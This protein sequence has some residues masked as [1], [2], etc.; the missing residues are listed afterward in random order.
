MSC[1]HKI[2][3][4]NPVSFNKKI[5]ENER[6]LNSQRRFF[7]TFNF[8]NKDFDKWW[9]NHH[10]AAFIFND[11]LAMPESTRYLSTNPEAVK[12]WSQTIVQFD[13]SSVLKNGIESNTI[14]NSLSPAEKA[15]LK[16]VF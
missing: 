1:T 15:T 4:S 12:S 6:L 3:S 2:V 13:Y 9:H 14:I 8:V 7:Y 16:I 5:R 10:S 11:L